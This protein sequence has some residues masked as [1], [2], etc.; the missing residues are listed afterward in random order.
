MTYDKI[1]KINKKIALAKIKLKLLWVGFFTK[2]KQG[3][4]LAFYF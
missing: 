4:I 3:A 2:I 1:I